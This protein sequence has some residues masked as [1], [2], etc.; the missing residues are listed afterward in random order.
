MSAATST[1][2]S[3]TLDFV[4]VNPSTTPGWGVSSAALCDALAAL[5]YTVQEIV[6]PPR[7]LGRAAGGLGYVSPF[8][9]LV[10]ALAV[11]VALARAVSSGLRFRRIVYMSSTAAMLEPRRRQRRGALRV[12]T[13]AHQSRPGRRNTVLRL[14]ER[15][16]LRSVQSVW[17]MNLS[18]SS[19]TGDESRTV[20]IPPLVKPS[21]EVQPERRDLVVVYAN[22]PKKRLDILL[23]A[24]ERSALSREG[25]RLVVA[26]CTREVGGTLIAPD[27]PPASVEFAGLLAPSEFRA[28]TRQATVFLA[29]PEYEHFG[30][31]PLEAMADGC[32][33]ATTRSPGPYAALR[34]VEREAPD[35][36][37]EFHDH[38]GLAHVLQWVAAQSEADVSVLRDR[39]TAAVVELGETQFRTH[40]REAV[41][42]L[43]R[44]GLR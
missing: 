12:D 24:W 34:V 32:L 6:A 21:A 40:L 29:A 23:R 3:E 2:G 39:L 43:D 37:A 18:D 16:S 7:R 26:G 10:E 19:A 44:A 20:V 38:D 31:A 8:M 33:L 42:A 5:G 30:I 9:D 15:R 41:D 17:S 1:P 27:Q 11:R 36:V 28:L 13:F 22:G 25:W 35:L 14:L 4:V